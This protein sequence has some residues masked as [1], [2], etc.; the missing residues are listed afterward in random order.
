VRILKPRK[1]IP[2]TACLKKDLKELLEYVATFV[3]F[4]FDYIRKAESDDDNLENNFK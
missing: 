4:L 3:L 2:T 1:T